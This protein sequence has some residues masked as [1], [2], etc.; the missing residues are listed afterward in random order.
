M[1][2]NGG[3]DNE[4]KKSVMM[5]NVNLNKFHNIEGRLDEVR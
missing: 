4:R 3:Y 2:Y 1:L 5:I